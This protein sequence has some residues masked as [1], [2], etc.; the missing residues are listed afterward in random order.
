M[1]TKKEQ[2]VDVTLVNQAE[3]ARR[4]AAR[5]RARDRRK[6]LVEPIHESAQLTADDYAIRINAKA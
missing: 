1:T 3:E 2:P 5:Q 6:A 4:E